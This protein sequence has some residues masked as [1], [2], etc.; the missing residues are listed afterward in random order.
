MINQITLFCFYS[1]LFNFQVNPNFY[2]IFLF[3]DKLKMSFKLK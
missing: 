3:L 2:W 1:T